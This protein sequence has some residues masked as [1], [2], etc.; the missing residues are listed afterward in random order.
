MKL[1]EEYGNSCIEA[2]FC[3]YNHSICIPK[4]FF[5][6][7]KMFMTTGFLDFVRRPIGVSCPS[8]E[9]GNR[10]SFRNVVFFCF[11]E[12]R[13]MDKVQKPSSLECLY[14][15][16]NPLKSTY[17]NVTATMCFDEYNRTS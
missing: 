12:Y 14:H 8:P 17:E 9:D 2:L 11:I 13:T 7:M 10:S 4:A 5:P 3:L 1:R 15:R 6:T 16:Q